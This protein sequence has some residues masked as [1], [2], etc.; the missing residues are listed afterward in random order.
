MLSHS[1]SGLQVL[2][3]ADVPPDAAFP[4]A[5]EPSDKE[6][7]QEASPRMGGADAERMVLVL[8]EQ[9]AFLRARLV[10][11]EDHIKTLLCLLTDW[12]KR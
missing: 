3:Q 11:A 9:N 6:P 7:L 10:A 1:C 2:A 8:E 4:Q 5:D 12:E